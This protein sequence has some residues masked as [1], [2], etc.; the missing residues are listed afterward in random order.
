MRNPN[1]PWEIRNDA[2]RRAWVNRGRT[3]FVYEMWQR[4]TWSG[5]FDR[6]WRPVRVLPPP[7]LPRIQPMPDELRETYAEIRRET[8][9]LMGLP[10]SRSVTHDLDVQL[11]RELN[12]M[13]LLVPE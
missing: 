7:T 11:V 5:T 10:P 12:L 4:G 8:N 1:A 2:A 13:R 9:R 3:R 6:N